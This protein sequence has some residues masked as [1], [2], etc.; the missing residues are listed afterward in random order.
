MIQIDELLTAVGISPICECHNDFKSR[1]KQDPTCTY[2]N[3][4][5]YLLTDIKELVISACAE[6][7]QLCADNATMTV[8]R[9]DN[10]I[11]KGQLAWIAEDNDHL[12]I[13]KQS[14]LNAPTPELK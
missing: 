3:Y 10:K 5:K 12:E 1:D 2:C 6:Q 7:R 4:G 13:D 9:S 11:F 14:I 8:E